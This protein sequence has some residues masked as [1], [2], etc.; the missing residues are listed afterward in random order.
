MSWISL[1]AE[2]SEAVHDLY[3]SSD[4]AVAI[5]A[6]TLVEARIKTALLERF[7]RH[8]KIEQNMFRST[9]PLGSL[10][11]K[12]DMILLLNIVSPDAHRD[13]ET[14]KNIRNRFAHYLDIKDFESQRIADWCKN[15]RL[16][17][18]HFVD[19]KTLASG[20]ANP[21]GLNL[22]MAI[23]DRD[24]KLKSPRWRYLMTAMLFAAAFAFHRPHGMVRL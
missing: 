9:G 4:R 15:L 2:E 5:I 22:Q 3:Q 6:A 11:A 16:I 13:L 14:M 1:S 24:E 23:E 21:L 18:R 10:S 20:E 17:E 19:P 8:E 12:I 7:E